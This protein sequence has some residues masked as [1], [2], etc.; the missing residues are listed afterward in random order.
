MSASERLA[1][2]IS[3]NDA[4]VVRGF[5][6]IGTA[7]EK[8]LGKADN[9]LDKF[10]TRATNVGAG[11]V[12]FAGIA[13]GALVSLAR[14]SEEANRS[15][16]ELQSTIANAPALAGE[17]AD[18]FN[19]LAK[20]I[21]S[22]TAADG[23]AIVSG[24][25]VLGN[26]G[27]TADQLKRLTP[28]LVDYAQR[29]GKDMASAAGD[30]GKALLGQGRALK[31]IGVDFTDTGTRAGN[32]DQLVGSLAAKVGGFAE[33]EGATF[34]GRL[35]RFKNELG[36][37]Q[38]GLGV[39]VLNAFESVL[40]PA[41]KFSSWLANTSP[42]T[43]E[44][45]GRMLALGTAGIGAVGGLSLI[46]GQLVKLRTRFVQLEGPAAGSLNTFGKLA[47]G[48]GIAAGIAG[49]ALALNE[50]RKEFSGLSVDVEAA[51]RAT[52][53]DLVDQFLLLRDAVDEGQWLKAFGKVA[54]ENIGTAKRLRDALQAQGEDVS[55]LDDALKSEAE[56]QRQASSDTAA[57][58]EIVDGATGAY[59]DM[60]DA[61]QD[62]TKEIQEF[63]DSL[64]PALDA[65]NDVIDA[66][67]NYE[68]SVNRT[69]D[70]LKDYAEKA[71]AAS[72]AGGKSAE[73]NEALERASLDVEQALLAQ[74]RAA[75]DA[76]RG[77]AE[78]EGKTLGA[79]DA[80]KLQILQLQY[81]VAGMDK[82]SPLRKAIEEHIWLLAS[83]PREITTTAAFKS[84]VRQDEALAANRGGAGGLQPGQPT[85]PA[86]G[87]SYGAQSVV[88]N[89]D[90][91]GIDDPIAI[92]EVINR[93]TGG[94]LAAAGGI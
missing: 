78:L 49:I 31:A 82:N 11:M 21:Q 65:V 58:A 93:H 34:S 46:A 41:T 9:R 42:E 12:A 54:S 67:L 57:G 88:V 15:Q 38:E 18:Q 27:L 51:A 69:E 17:T 68:E 66:G 81:M 39:G 90:A 14:A 87:G 63:T 77:Q 56:A 44:F 20:A 83:I 64:G 72:D 10:G 92:V 7:A 3:V 28:L 70:A 80:A 25:A 13:G 6:K 61:V 86:S 16:I 59:G 76:A 35:Q 5:Q 37:L 29:T 2:L 36:D 26:F 32:F 48:A 91:R 47:R 55:A 53:T 60:G 1:Y 33:R 23:D 94:A 19:D 50:V 4:Q 79:E 75:V 45:T 89:V 74:S 22:K 73:A 52:G 30:L 40:T 71:K 43:Q 84:A 85:A 24:I 8:E 62:T